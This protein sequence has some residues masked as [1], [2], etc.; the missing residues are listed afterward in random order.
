MKKERI[1]IIIKNALDYIEEITKYER[2]EIASVL[3]GMTEEEF[4]EIEGE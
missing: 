1:E 4:K 3:L 2:K